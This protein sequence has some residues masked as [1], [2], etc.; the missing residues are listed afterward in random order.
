ML[1]F[2]LVAFV[3]AATIQWS[4]RGGTNLWDNPSNWDCN[5]LP[6]N[7]DDVIISFSLGATAV[8]IGTPARAKTLTIGGTQTNFTQ[9]LT[10]SGTLSIG[11]GTLNTN[12]ALYIETSPTNPFNITGG[13]FTAYGGGLLF[14]SGLVGG[15]G[16]LVVPVGAAMNFSG[17]AAKEIAGNIAIYGSA[18]VSSSASASIFLREKGSLNIY[19]SM[20]SKTSLDILVES[21]ASFN[22]ASNGTFVMNGGPSSKL[23]LQGNINIGKWQV[24]AGFVQVVNKIVSGSLVMDSASTLS[25][26]GGP[27]ES[28]NFAQI[29]GGT[30]QQQGGTTT[31]GSISGSAVQ[32]TG[33]SSSFTSS[34]NLVNLILNGG[35]VTGGTINSQASSI[36]YAVFTSG[37]K[38]I[39]TSVEFKGLLTLQDDGTA[40]VISQNGQGRVTA[41]SQITFL[42]ASSFTVNSGSVIQQ[43]SNLNLVK[44][45]AKGNNPILQQ[46]GNWQ[47]GATLS[48]NGVDVTGSGSFTIG[49]TSTFNWVN[50]NF[51]TQNLVSQGSFTYLSGN[52]NIAS[53]TGSGVFAGAPAAFNA[54]SFASAVFNLTDGAASLTKSNIQQVTLTNGN[55]GLSSGQIGTFNLQGGTLAGVG[56]SASVKVTQLNVVGVPAKTLTGIA[57]TT[58]KLNL[59]CGPNQCAL[60]TINASVTVSSAQ[61]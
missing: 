6:T 54:A 8:R 40:L 2:L 10:V 55:L 30:I 17:P 53:V 38:L 59:A 23:L 51:A 4:G 61:K 35:T 45:S 9:S 15:A 44:G 37:A 29:S 19:G 33:G 22:S 25:L 39:S 43:T 16:Q 52:F 42:G 50:A 12:G 46:N 27:T 48:S 21:A 47:A 28:R 14:T 60:F 58:T 34:V 11:G 13:V 32:L 57:V 7:N 31:Y 18:Y 41:D 1:V 24:I 3:N 5:C 56:V 49:S 26:I 36:T 20:E